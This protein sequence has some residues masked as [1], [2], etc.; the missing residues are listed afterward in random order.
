MPLYRL[1]EASRGLVKPLLRP[2]SRVHPDLITWL[3]LL[4]SVGAGV[5][6]YFMELRWPLICAIAL[7]LLRMVSNLLDGMI[8]RQQARASVRGE[9]LAEACDR[10]ADMAILLGVALAPP[11]S[12]IL[13]IL[14]LGLAF[15]T[16][17]LDIR[18]R[19]LAGKK[20]SVG[21]MD[22][23]DRLVALMVAAVLGFFLPLP[24][25]FNIAFGIII[26][27]SVLTIFQRWFVLQRSLKNE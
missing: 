15:M 17:Y 12:L 16:E 21:I 19:G 6:F 4:V 8:A 10:L 20:T 23:I 13:G 27:G 22:K 25:V 11:V 2:L 7:I 5:S 9:A 14:A 18:A 24:W 26:A 1:R 3:G